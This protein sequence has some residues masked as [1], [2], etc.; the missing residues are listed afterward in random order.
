M[1][2]MRQ[3]VRW[4]VRGLRRTPG[5]AVT[6]CLTLAL[7]IGLSVAVFTIADALLIQKFPV[8]D[9]DRIVLLAGR[10]PD[11]G[12]ENWPLDFEG[13]KA[14]AQRARAF[15]RMAYFGYEGASAQTMR[16]DGQTSRIHR[17]LVSGEYFTVLGSVP[18][19]GRALRPDDDTRGA[20]PVAVLSHRAWQERFGGAVDVV[21]RR[22]TLHEAGI[23]YT[24]VGVM[25]QG[26]DYP[27]GVD[28]WAAIEP[29]TPEEVLALLAY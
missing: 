14:F 2:M 13:A 24:V 3:N 12:V 11:R 23:V 28:F 8:L 5:F 9:Q 29:A 25:E 27:R 22:I 7:G 21:G 4:A 18:R 15:S 10:T 17:A 16:D 6:A 26:L 1:E 19:L 20:A